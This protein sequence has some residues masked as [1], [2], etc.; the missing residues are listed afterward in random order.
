MDL[1]A[2]RTCGQRGGLAL[3]CRGAVRTMPIF[4]F[5]QS[6]CGLQAVKLLIPRLDETL[7]PSAFFADKDK[8]V[9][10]LLHS[11]L[12]RLAEWEAKIAR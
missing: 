10:L 11:Y 6:I 9:T 8:L 3:R 4:T 1:L 7:A 5:S 2:L 12:W